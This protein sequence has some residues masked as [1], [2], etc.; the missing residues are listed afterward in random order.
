MAWNEPGKGNNNG[1]QQ[2]GPPELEKIFKDL[3]DKLSG[4]FGKKG[5]SSSN[6]SGAASSKGSKAF[7]IGGIVV[8]IIIWILSGIFIVAPAE[9]GV[10]LQFGKYYS[11]VNPGPHW[12]PR[13]IQSEQTVNV[14]KIS[15][16]SYN[17]QMLTKDQNIVDVAVSVQYK[18]SNARN[19]L[20]N[21][22]NPTSS[23]QQATASALRQVMGDTTLDQVLTSGRSVVRQSVFEQLQKILK[24][25]NPGIEITD[26]ALQPARAPVEVKAAFDD[27]IKAQEDEQ[28]YQNQAEAYA[29]GVVPIAQG[30]AKR[31]IQEANAYQQQVILQ[32]E[33]NVARFNA[34]YTAYRQAPSVTKERLYLQAM[35]D[36]LTKSTKIFI[37]TKGS[38]NLLYLPFDKLLAQAGQAKAP[39]GDDHV[40]NLS[41]I[42]NS[43]DST[44]DAQ[45]AVSQN[46]N[47]DSVVGTRGERP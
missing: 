34:L 1:S 6:G 26:V 36:V 13:F 5:K 43:A 38:N 44:G 10:V 21:V 37:D 11:T 7:F 29:N 41:S 20:F 12:V 46:A 47:P 32:A 14:Q 9:K 18:I 2:D 27:A 3:S 40:G 45:Q 23:L 16:Y 8:I 30:Q 31:I 17:A 28:R 25:Y 33:G 39:T 4:L 19:Y 42:L 24:L 22:N 15:T 35:Q